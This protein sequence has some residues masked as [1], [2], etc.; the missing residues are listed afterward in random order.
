M[1][2][3]RSR[4]ATPWPPCTRLASF[5]GAGRLLAWC[6]WFLAARGRCLGALGRRGALPDV[7][8]AGAKRL[9]D[10]T[11]AGAG[12]QVTGDRA[13]LVHLVADGIGGGQAEADY[14]LVGCLD[15]QAAFGDPEQHVPPAALL[16]LLVAGAGDVRAAQRVPHPVQINAEAG[17]RAGRGRVGIGE[18][19]EQQVVR[20]DR[21]GSGEPRGLV[22]A[23]LGGR[24]RA[25]L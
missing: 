15:R 10:G 1:T 4:P 12:G 22:Q 7:F 6:G 16:R 24:R 21:A 17:E 5:A 3:P 19:R 11:E 8:E 14:V 9:P 23:G 25:Y 20:A 2:A 18:R 13:R